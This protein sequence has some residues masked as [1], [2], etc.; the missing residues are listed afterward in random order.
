MSNGVHAEVA[1][2]A[3]LAD[4]PLRALCA[5]RDLCVMEEVEE[6]RCG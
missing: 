6:S 5:L 2:S 1:E 3:E 4:G